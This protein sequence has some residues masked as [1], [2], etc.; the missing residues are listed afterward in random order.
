MRLLGPYPLMIRRLFVLSFM[1]AVAASGVA[2][3]EESYW[4]NGVEADSYGV[5]LAL[6]ETYNNLGQYSEAIRVL[7][8]IDPGRLA[9]RRPD[10]KRILA[11]A[12]EGTGDRDPA[13][14]E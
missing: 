7:Q 10:F 9:D 5:R 3:T 2:T 1:T 11:H 14:R 13:A 6:G 12:H 8:D 4:D